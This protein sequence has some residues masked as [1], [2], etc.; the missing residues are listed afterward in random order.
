MT[1]K[2]ICDRCKKK[3]RIKIKSYE[4]TF[5]AECLNCMETTGFDQGKEE[6]KLTD[7]EKEKKYLKPRSEGW[8]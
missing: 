1:I 3:A 4:E 8:I 5:I 6:D 7:K 2:I